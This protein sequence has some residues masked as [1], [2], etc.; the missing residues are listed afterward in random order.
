MFMLRFDMRAPVDGPAGTGDLYAAAIDMAVWAEEHGALAVVLS[1]HHAS[2]DGYLPS[3]LVLAA[4]MAARTSTVPIT[5]AALLVPLHDPVRLAED[6]AVLDVVSG[7]R[8]S[9]VAGLGYR[10]EEYAMFGRSLG[11]RGRRMEECLTV[12]RAAWTGEVFDYEGRTVRV[13]PTPPTPGGPMLMYG[14]GS[15]AAARR[16]ARFGMSFFAQASA[17]G[18]EEAYAEECARAGTEPGMCFVPPPGSPT[19]VFVAEDPDEGWARYGPYMLHDARMYASWLGDAA[20]AS[21]S[22][23]VTVES[24]RAEGG[25]Y[26]VVTPAEAVEQVREF[27]SLNLH[28]LCGGCPPELAWQSLRLVAEQVLPALG[29]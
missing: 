17:P 3:P 24:L 27:G 19:S 25:A 11:E 4:A 20:A 14:G 22:N 29:A 6:M 9:Y 1:E 5:V 16:A 13:T 18:L 12:L 2:P 21:K 23:A 26:R 10:P 15:T 28:P 8:V 7:G